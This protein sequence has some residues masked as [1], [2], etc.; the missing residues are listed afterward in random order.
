[1]PKI[2]PQKL[3]ENF[4]NFTLCVY[5]SC[6]EQLRYFI[7]VCSLQIICQTKEK[8]VNHEKVG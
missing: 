3:E 1:M 4:I 2:A 5:S 7:F 8:A 6:E